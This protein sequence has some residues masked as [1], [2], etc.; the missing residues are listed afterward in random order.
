MC[1]IETDSYAE[2]WEETI[3][4]KSRKDHKCSCC[5]TTIKSASSY[6]YHFDVFEGNASTEKMCMD[7]LSDR[8]KFTA[9]HGGYVP[10]PSSFTMMLQDCIADG[11]EE[12][13]KIWEPMLRK[14]D[15]RIR[16]SR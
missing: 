8:W 16:S 6:L 7:C 3:I 4:Q 14:I 2:V 12:S 11:D 15:D 10:C 5:G 1:V 9:E 13:E